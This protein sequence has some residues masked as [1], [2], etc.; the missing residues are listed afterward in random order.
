MTRNTPDTME[1]PICDGLGMIELYSR[2]RTRDGRYILGKARDCPDCDG[3]G[4]I[5]APSVPHI[6]PTPAAFRIGRG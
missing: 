3:T 1:C 6:A 2:H 5:P 4:R